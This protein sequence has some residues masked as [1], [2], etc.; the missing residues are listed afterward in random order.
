MIPG[1]CLWVTSGR[2]EDSVCLYLLAKRLFGLESRNTIDD[3]AEGPSAFG[4]ARHKPSRV[5]P[6]PAFVFCIF[7]KSLILMRGTKVKDLFLL[8]AGIVTF[9]LVLGYFVKFT[10]TVLIAVWGVVMLMIILMRKRI[11]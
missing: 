2:Q 3:S 4:M 7:S 10:T 1:A 11:A 8:M 6:I 5:V 9:I